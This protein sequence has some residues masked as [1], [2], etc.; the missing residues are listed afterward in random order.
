[1]HMAGFD[2]GR[3]RHH[4]LD[5]AAV[6]LDPDG[7]GHA[8]WEIT[9]QILQER[10]SGP[11]LFD[12]DSFGTVPRDKAC[13]LAPKGGVL[14]PRAKDVDEI[15]IRLDHAPGCTDRIVIGLTGH[16]GDVP[17]LHDQIAWTGPGRL[18]IKPEPVR[19]DGIAFERHWP[20]L[21]LG[22]EHQ[23]ADLGFD[24]LEHRVALPLRMQ[25]VALAAG[26]ELAVPNGD[27]A[28]LNGDGRQVEMLPAALSEEMPGKV[29]LMQALHDHDN[30][31]FLLVVEARDQGAAV[32]VDH[33][34]P[35]RLRHRL[36]VLGRVFAHVKTSPPPRY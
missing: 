8:N 23:A 28:V 34:P 10:Q 16:H 11:R 25:D 36:F 32:P 22:G 31:T 24:A 2:L 12:Q 21:V 4:A 1:M 27:D 15:V 13:D 9:S 7:A 17:A 6:G 5:L 19:L 33:P 26:E 35:R 14:E 30:G 18:V 20:L 29:I 3:L